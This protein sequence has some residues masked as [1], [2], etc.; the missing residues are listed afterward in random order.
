MNSGR[1]AKSVPP[2]VAVLSKAQPRP[3]ATE[4]LMEVDRRPQAVG[5]CWWVLWL[6]SSLPQL[7]LATVL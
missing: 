1:G 2:A 7:C 6:S 4:G 3:L 5:A